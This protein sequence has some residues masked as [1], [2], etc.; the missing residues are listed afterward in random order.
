MGEFRLPSLGADLK[1]GKLVE[2]LVGPGDHV[3]PGDSVAVVETDMTTLDVE[4]QQE[5]QVTELLVDIGTTVPVGTPMVRILGTEEE[6]KKR[7]SRMQRPFRR[8]RRRTG[9]RASGG[10]SGR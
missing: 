3:S 8:P 9:C 5:G 7:S 1:N 2:W 6:E 10:P 4:T